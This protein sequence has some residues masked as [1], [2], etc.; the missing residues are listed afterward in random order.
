MSSE[1]QRRE[2]CFL[3]INQLIFFTFSLFKWV[4]NF[5]RAM[6]CSLCT[7]ESKDIEKAA[8]F[9]FP[10]SSASKIQIKT[11]CSLSFSLHQRHQNH[12]NTR[13]VLCARV[14]LKLIS[15]PSMVSLCSNKLKTVKHVAMF[16]LRQWVQKGWMMR[17]M[18]S[19]SLVTSSNLKTPR[20]MFPLSE[21]LKIS[22]L[23]SMSS[24]FKWAQI[25]ENAGDVLSRWMSPK[26]RLLIF[27]FLCFPGRP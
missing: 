5:A 17:Y 12:N 9:F 23:V 1:V 21:R 15:W 2:L 22:L 27:M 10:A 6:P 7:N 20:C 25:W 14:T 19:L 24:L 4:Q 3:C 16:C 13:H 11:T 8:M 26:S 18:F